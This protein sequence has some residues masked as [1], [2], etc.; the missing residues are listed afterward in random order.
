MERKATIQGGK[1]IL[2]K[3][4]TLAI[5]VHAMSRFKI[6]LTLCIKLESLIENF[7]RRQRENEQ[8]IH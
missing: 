1:E 3:S 4:I 5:S 2:L 6:S 8:K 7:W